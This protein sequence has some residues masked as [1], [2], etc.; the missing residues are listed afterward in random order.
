[1]RQALYRAR[2]RH[3]A[4]RVWLRE[5]ALTIQGPLVPAPDPPPD[6]HPTFAEIRLNASIPWEIEFH[7]GASGLKANLG[8]LQLLSLDLLGGATHIELELSKPTGTAFIYISGGLSQGV[9]RRPM[10]VAVRL[11]VGG[12]VR[13]LVFDGR[14]LGESSEDTR[15]ETPGFA[16]AASAYEICITGGATDVT[17]GSNLQ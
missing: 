13:E 14:H 4:P 16:D 17:I 11:Q 10:G 9:I 1:M 6:S 15:V 5:G 8:R 12:G 3:P 2:F 7:H